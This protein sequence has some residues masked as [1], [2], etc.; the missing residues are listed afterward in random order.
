M[1]YETKCYILAIVVMFAS[2]GVAYYMRE[3]DMIRAYYQ[4]WGV[5]P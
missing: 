2:I 4:F 3:T 5:V 1:M